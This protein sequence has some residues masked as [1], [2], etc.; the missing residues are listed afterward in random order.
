[1]KIQWISA[2][3][4]REKLSKEEWYAQLFSLSFILLPLIQLLPSGVGLTLIPLIFIKWASVYYQKPKLATYCIFPSFFL[5]IALCVIMFKIESITMGFLTLLIMMCA[6]KLLESRNIRDMHI[7]FLTTLLLCLANL[8]FSQSFLLFIYVI[9]A[10]LFAFNSLAKATERKSE[11]KKISGFSSM[12]GLFALSLPIVLLLFFAVPRIA[13]IWGMH[14]QDNQGITGLPDEMTMDGI[15]HLAQ[16]SETVFRVKFDGEI[17]ASKYLY[18]RGPV[19]WDFDGSAWKPRRGGGDFYTTAE[20]LY[21]DNSSIEQ[22]ASYSIRLAKNDIKFLTALE[23]PLSIQGKGKRRQYYMGAARQIFLPPIIRGEQ[24]FELKSVFNY[25][26]SP[27]ALPRKDYHSATRIPEHLSYPKTEALAQRLWKEGGENAEGFANRFLKY[28]QEENFHYTL[29][30][31]EGASD[32]EKFLFEDQSRGGF[33]QHYS[34]AM[35]LTARLAGI[36]SRVV[37]GY[38]GGRFN[39]LSGDFVVREENAHAWV[40]LWIEDKGWTRFDPTAAVS[41]LRVDS[42]GLSAEVLEGSG[43]EGKISLFSRLAQKY[44]AF[45]LLR[46]SIDY[47][48]SFWQNQ[49][50]NF[51][52]E[53]QLNLFSALGFSSLKT[54]AIA[55]LVFIT[56][57]ILIL[58]IFMFWEKQKQ[59]PTDP[60][61]L[62]AFKLLKRLEAKGMGKYDFESFAAFLRRLALEKN[63]KNAEAFNNAALAYENLRYREKGDLKE[64]IKKIKALSC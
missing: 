15:S 52:E 59:L 3:E 58:V 28:I 20:Q 57:L 21:S 64:A 34:N 25:R 27:N 51:D 56:A 16:S 45:A 41:P 23:M 63:L 43:S 62:A 35:A 22:S 50:V 38:Q 36:P 2:E 37:I 46:D 4:Y 61:S 33:C 30:P 24:K 11:I 42:S 47:V 48:Q 26:L 32:V 31:Y 49:V 53:K 60:L 13:P 40:E 39:E 54:G 5:A 12:L 10:V 9:T 29:E 19:L 44:K 6:C 17:P 55:L 7:L 14:R 18:W 1:M 8:M